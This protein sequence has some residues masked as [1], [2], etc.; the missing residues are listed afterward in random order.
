MKI[1][2]S[3]LS[4]L[5]HLQ[6][7]YLGD[8]YGVNLGYAMY[9]ETDICPEDFGQYWYYYDFENTGDWALD[10]TVTVHCV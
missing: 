9:R 7:W 1:K 3:S 2:C 5:I 6:I 10:E 8:N 4:I